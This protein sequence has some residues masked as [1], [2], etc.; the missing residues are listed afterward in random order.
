MRA[1]HQCTCHCL[2]LVIHTFQQI[3]ADGNRAG[4]VSPTNSQPGDAD[5]AMYLNY[6]NRGGF[7]YEIN[8]V[9]YTPAINVSAVFRRVSAQYFY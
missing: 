6:H 5:T 8:A 1:Q 3:V 7:R 4:R 9:S 2:H